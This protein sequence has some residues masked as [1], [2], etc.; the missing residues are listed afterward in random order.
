[1]K[2]FNRREQD[3]TYITNSALVLRPVATSMY[4]SQIRLAALFSKGIHRKPPN[5]RSEGA[6]LE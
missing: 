2:Q 6:F 1:M 3:F 5:F 4:V